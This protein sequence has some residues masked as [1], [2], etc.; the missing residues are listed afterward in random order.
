MAAYNRT[1]RN[2]KRD[3][4]DTRYTTPICTPNIKGYGQTQSIQTDTPP[5]RQTTTTNCGTAEQDRV[6][7]ELQLENNEDKTEKNN[8]QVQAG[9]QYEDDVSKYNVLKQS[10]GE[11][12]I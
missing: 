5:Y 6:N 3:S 1:C 2:S 12:F 10:A 9:W 4:N 11:R 8:I 7:E